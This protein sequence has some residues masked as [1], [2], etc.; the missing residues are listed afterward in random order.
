MVARQKTKEYA[1]GDFSDAIEKGLLQIIMLGRPKIKGRRELLN[2]NSSINYGDTS[3][4]SQRVK[5]KAHM[6]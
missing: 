2:L 5:G 3:L 4:S 6:L 1:S